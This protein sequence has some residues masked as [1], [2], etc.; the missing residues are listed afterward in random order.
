MEKDG[1]RER[2]KGPSGTALTSLEGNGGD[3][4]EKGC[5]WTSVAGTHHISDSHGRVTFKCDNRS[6]SRKQDCASASP[7][8]ASHSFTGPPP[9]IKKKKK[10]LNKN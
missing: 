2:G 3:K 5:K 4:Y 7:F 10:T 8:L 6:Q 1:V 9:Y